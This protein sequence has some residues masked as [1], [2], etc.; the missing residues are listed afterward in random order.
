MVRT[1]I[2]IYFTIWEK[3]LGPKGGEKLQVGSQVLRFWRLMPKGRKYLAQSKRTAPPPPFQ[4]FK[5]K[6]SNWYLIKMNF[7]LV[8]EVNF[9]IGISFGISKLFFKWVSSKLHISMKDF[10]W[11]NFTWYLFQNPL[12]S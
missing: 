1:F 7:Q 5:N 3:V 12:E 11:Y 10:N 8:C 6:Y 4:N 9:S 2:C